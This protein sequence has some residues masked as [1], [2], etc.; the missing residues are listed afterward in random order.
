MQA[1]PNFWQI[2][3][4][5][6]EKHHSVIFWSICTLFSRN[7]IWKKLTF[8]L[9]TAFVERKTKETF[10]LANQDGWEFVLSWHRFD[11]RTVDFFSFFWSVSLLIEKPKH[12]LQQKHPVKDAKSNRLYSCHIEIRLRKIRSQ[13]CRLQN[14]GFFAYLISGERSPNRPKKLRNNAFQN[15]LVCQKLARSCKKWKSAQNPKYARFASRPSIVIQSAQIRF[16]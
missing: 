13:R 16:L 2:D 14:W 8:P 7:N 12:L 5:W 1:N 11:T 15:K 4:F 6:H 3:L 9:E 10:C